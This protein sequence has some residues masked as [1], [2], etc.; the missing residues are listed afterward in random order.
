MR[1]LE[2]S[3]EERYGKLKQ[4]ALKYKKKLAEQTKIIE[5]LQK[6]LAA[7]KAKVAHQQ[8]D[9]TTAAAAGGTAA[10]DALRHCINLVKEFK[11]E[12][13]QIKSVSWEYS[14]DEEYLEELSK[15]K[16]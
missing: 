14:C 11:T 12:A 16:I 9:E 5:E 6:S 10:H 4:I 3:F 15:G 13:N 1:D 7:V 2:D 8:Q